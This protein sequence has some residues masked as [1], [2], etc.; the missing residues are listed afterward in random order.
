LQ[1]NQAAG[2]G[3][4]RPDLDK[5]RHDP[6]SPMRR[7]FLL[8]VFAMREGASFCF[9]CRAPVIVIDSPVNNWQGLHVCVF[10]AQPRSGKNRKIS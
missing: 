2:T 7:N 9:L 5:A 6:A 10:D 4:L 1:T 3:R 8:C